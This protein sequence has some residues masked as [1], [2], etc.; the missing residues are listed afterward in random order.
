MRKIN[1]Y[2]TL[3]FI[4]LISIQFQ[5]RALAS[6]AQLEIYTP[7]TK[8]SVSPGSTVNYSIDII[9]NGDETQN[10]DIL[11]TNLPRSWSYTLTANGLNINKV[12]VLPKEKKTLSLKVEVP[13]QVKKGYYTFYAKTGNGA[14]LPMTVN[15]STAGSN[16]TELSCDQRNMQGTSKSNFTFNAVL[17]NKTPNKQQYALMASP[18]KGWIVAIKP[19]HKQ[20]TST[21]V[22][23]NGTKN[24]SYDIKAPSNVNAGSYK[25]PVKAVSGS[26][27]AEMELEVVIT[28]TYK[29]VLTTPTGLLSAR[30]TAGDEKKVELAIK[31][32]GSVKLENIELSASKPKNWEV[33]FDNKEIASLEP[34]KTTTVLASIKADKKA[35]P[36]DYVTKI[37]ARTP[38]TNEQISFRIMVKTPML[39]GWLGVLVILAAIGGLWLLIRKFGRR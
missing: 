15:V 8:V 29:M 37:T 26:T 12:A 19:N 7:Y 13:Y 34:G 32:T 27:S 20:A 3:L 16:E 11:I 2:M 9:N 38:E 21:E 10:Q 5:Q 23:A 36:G 35:I 4:A 24:I 18:P 30:I 14:S 39:M 17:K 25:I 1:L 28:G 33:S 22:D 31:N 6:S